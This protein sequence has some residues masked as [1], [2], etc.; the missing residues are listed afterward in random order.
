MRQHKAWNEK[1]NFLWIKKNEH[2]FKFSKLKNSTIN[3]KFRIR[4]FPS[5]D[6]FPSICMSYM[7]M[8]KI[9]AFLITCVF[10]GL[11]CAFLFW[12]KSDIWIGIPVFSLSNADFPKWIWSELRD[13]WYI[14]SSM[15]K[16]Y[17]F[18][19]VAAVKCVQF[20]CYG[21]LN[22]SFLMNVLMYNWY[23]I[24]I[25]QNRLRHLFRSIFDDKIVCVRHV[26][27]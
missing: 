18:F 2:C 17:S 3:H 21:L 13:L 27:I 26:I 15:R 23:A 11:V 5:R 8:V 10:S 1:R 9:F 7:N 24:L 4:F 14:Q 19:F 12:W 16:W 20:P 22:K 6:F 25:K